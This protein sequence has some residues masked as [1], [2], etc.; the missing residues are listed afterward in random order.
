MARIDDYPAALQKKFREM[1]ADMSKWL[2]Q[3]GLPMKRPKNGG[4]DVGTLLP[5][6][7][8]EPFVI[9]VGVLTNQQKVTYRSLED[10]L[11]DDWVVD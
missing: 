10:L 3:S 2:N 9:C 4:L 11:N 1:I 8:G 7:D 6:N 5:R